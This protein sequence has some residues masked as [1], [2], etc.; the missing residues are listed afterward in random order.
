MS[1]DQHRLNRQLDRYTRRL[2][3]WVRRSLHWLRQPSARWVRI[4]AGL[5]LVA[6]GIFSVLPLLGLWMLP[7]GL[8]LLAQD[9]PFLR[10]PMRRTLV[11]L[12]HRS[13]RW[14]LRRQ[15]KAAAS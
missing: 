1:K 6:G 13:I 15:A 14:K 8:L 10:R 3:E 11:C 5:A 2:P 9:L 7:L 12:E 4:P